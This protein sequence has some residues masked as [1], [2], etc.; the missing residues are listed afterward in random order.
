M[1]IAVAYHFVASVAV[2]RTHD[3]RGERGPSRTPPPPYHLHPVNG[4]H[5]DMDCGGF[6]LARSMA[7]EAG[8]IPSLLT[9]PEPSP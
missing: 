5:G 6:N 1:E 3:L 2:V 7:A 8:S 4:G 9:V